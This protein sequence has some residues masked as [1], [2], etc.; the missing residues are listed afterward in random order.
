M[1]RFRSQLRRESDRGRVGVC[2]FEVLAEGR[3]FE[4]VSRRNNTLIVSRD[5]FRV[6]C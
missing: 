3:H 4:I 2:R 1:G 5:L 6:H